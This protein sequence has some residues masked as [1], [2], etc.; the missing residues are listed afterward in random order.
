VD[1]QTLFLRRVKQTASKLREQS[2]IIAAPQAKHCYELVP[3]FRNKSCSKK[4]GAK[5]KGQISHFLT[6]PPVKITVKKGNRAM[7]QQKPLL[8]I[9]ISSSLSTAFLTAEFKVTGK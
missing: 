9:K 6:L 4:S 7:S 5:D 3:S 8:I 2:S 1:F